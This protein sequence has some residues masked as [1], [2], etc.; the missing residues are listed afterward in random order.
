MRL[1]RP[2]RLNLTIYRVALALGVG[3]LVMAGGFRVILWL[4]SGV[5]HDRQYGPSRRD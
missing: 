3:V 2:M 5:N 1:P 4:L